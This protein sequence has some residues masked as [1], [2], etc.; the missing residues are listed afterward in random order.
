MAKPRSDTSPFMESLETPMPP[1]CFP[2]KVLTGPMCLQLAC[3]IQTFSGKH[4]SWV[5]AHTMFANMLPEQDFCSQ[6]GLLSFAS[7]CKCLSEG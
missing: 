6:S 2:L 1:A 4:R 7:P 3:S 5:L